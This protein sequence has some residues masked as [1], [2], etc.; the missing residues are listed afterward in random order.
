MSIRI[1]AELALFGVAAAG[2]CLEA[3]ANRGGKS[4]EFEE[5]MSIRL[6]GSQDWGCEVV[7]HARSRRNK[8]ARLQ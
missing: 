6:T 4:M 1:G 7:D 8:T 5:E 3:A 2:S